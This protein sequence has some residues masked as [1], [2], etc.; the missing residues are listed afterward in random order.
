MT[1]RRIAFVGWGVAAALAGGLAIAHAAGLRLNFTHSAP[2]GLW[3]VSG[4]PV[5]ALER[6]TLV[7]ACP[8]PVPVVIA[9]RER[10]YLA[11]NWLGNCQPAG[12]AALLKPVAAV[13]GDRVTLR[14]GAP[15]TVNG[16]V[17][18]NT[19]AGAAVPA[20]PD[21]D[22]TVQLGEVWLFSTYAAASF[23]SRYFGPVPVANLRGQAAPVLTRGD[24][25]TMTLGVPTP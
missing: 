14:R 16:A 19:T 5:G 1:A 13:A 12:V 15:A 4:L 10:G 23:D 9:M 21:G 8:P 18:P 22:Y 24:A 3:R 25:A 20:W 17:L 11:E 7:E 6:G 2:A